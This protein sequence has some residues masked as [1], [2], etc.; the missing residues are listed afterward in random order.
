MAFVVPLSLVG[1]TERT[2]Q[3]LCVV[4]G[5]RTVERSLFVQRYC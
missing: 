4:T 5:S 2:K 3:G 1:V